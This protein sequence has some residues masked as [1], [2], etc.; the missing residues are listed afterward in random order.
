MNLYLKTSPNCGRKQKYRYRKHKRP[1]Q[2][3]PKETYTRMSPLK[4]TLGLNYLLTFNEYIHILLHILL[5]GYL[6]ELSQDVISI[7]HLTSPHRDIA[8]NY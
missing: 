3:K 1:G 5:L 4:I 6:D 2:D 7:M 8:L